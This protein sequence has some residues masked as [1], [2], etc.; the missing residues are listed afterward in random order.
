LPSEGLVKIHDTIR[1]WTEN[2]MV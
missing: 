1:L 2:L